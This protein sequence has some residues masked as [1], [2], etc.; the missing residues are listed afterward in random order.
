M[1]LFSALLQ[2]DVVEGDAD[3]RL[4]ELPQIESAEEAS[5]EIIEPAQEVEGKHILSYHL[6][7]KSILPA[8]TFLIS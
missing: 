7:G 1:D 4:A 6:S 3:V 2:P 8:I 5:Q